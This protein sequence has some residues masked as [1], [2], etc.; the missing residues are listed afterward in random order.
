[1][2]SIKF[3]KGS[4]GSG[5]SFFIKYLTIYLTNQ[6]KNV[7]LSITIGAMAS[8]HLPIVETI[9]AQYKIPIGGYMNTLIEPNNTLQK[10]RPID[11][12]IINEMSLLTNIM[13]NSIY[14]RIK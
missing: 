9:H 4:L 7:L 8:R 12:F 2:T 6:G 1:M 14:T 10:L 13:L 5:K 11:V 3:L